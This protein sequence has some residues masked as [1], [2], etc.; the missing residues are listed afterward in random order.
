MMSGQMILEQTNNLSLS[1][2]S[3]ILEN[4]MFLCVSAA[5]FKSQSL[6]GPD[7]FVESNR[8]L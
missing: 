1:K 7:W 4:R 6:T 8:P 5:T 3:Q 2:N